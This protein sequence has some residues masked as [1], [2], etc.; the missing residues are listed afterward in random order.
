MNPDTTEQE[1]FASPLLVGWNAPSPYPYAEPTLCRESMLGG[2]VV[3]VLTYAATTY[4]RAHAVVQAADEPFSRTSPFLRL[5]DGRVL[6]NV[7]VFKS[8]ASLAKCLQRLARPDYEPRSFRGE[9]Q[10]EREREEQLV[11]LDKFFTPE[12]SI[13]RRLR[14]RGI[15]Q[16]V[17][18]SSGSGDSGGVEAIKATSR[19]GGIVKLSAGFAAELKEVYEYHFPYSYDN[20]GAEGELTLHVAERVASLRATAFETTASTRSFALE[21]GQ[22]PEA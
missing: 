11:K 5:P 2:R 6:R 9:R 3:R 13:W 17:I 1:H 20:E 16:L 18:Q 14:A 10:M 21:N 22:R 7:G 8:A 4:Q 19:D 12:S 15:K